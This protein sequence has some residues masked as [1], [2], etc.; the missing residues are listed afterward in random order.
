MKAWVFQ[1]RVSCFRMEGSRA[2]WGDQ[3]VRCNVVKQ[4]GLDTPESSFSLGFVGAFA[5]LDWTG[6]GLCNAISL[7][8][9]RRLLLL[10]LA[11]I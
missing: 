7:G 10:L 3:A 9:W 11:L 4:I 8:R 5:S 1:P 6:G 2:G